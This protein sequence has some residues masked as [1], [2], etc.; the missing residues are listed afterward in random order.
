M[1]K[2]AFDSFKYF[3]VCLHQLGTSGFGE[4]L[5]LFLADLLKYIEEMYKYIEEM[6]ALLIC[7]FGRTCVTRRTPRTS[8]HSFQRDRP[9]KTRHKLTRFS[10]QWQELPVGPVMTFSGASRLIS[11]SC[12][13][14]YTL[15][16]KPSGVNGNFSIDE[17]LILNAQGSV[18][19]SLSAQPLPGSSSGATSVRVRFTSLEPIMVGICGTAA[20]TE[21]Y[22]R[23]K[24]K[25][26]FIEKIRLSRLHDE[27]TMMKPGESINISIVLSND[28]AS[29]HFIINVKDQLNLLT[30]YSPQNVSLDQGHNITIVSTFSAPA[31]FNNHTSSLVRVVVKTRG[32]APTYNYLTFAVTTIPKNALVVDTEPPNV[33]FTGSPA[34]CKAEHQHG[35]NCSTYPWELQFEAQDEQSKANLR[36]TVIR[37]N[38][39]GVNSWK[40]GDVMVGNYSSSCCFPY[41]EIKI[42]DMYGNTQNISLDNSKDPTPTPSATPTVTPTPTITPNATETTTPSA[43]PTPTV[44]SSATLPPRGPAHCAHLTTRRC[45]GTGLF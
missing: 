43:T 27:N 35:E 7:P 21:K 25:L 34:N 39:T 29:D 42:S 23:L 1:T 37:G 19:Q 5:P 18:V 40:E 28:G 22:Y 2:N 36:V 31:E 33:N 38:Q 20:E 3:W 17:V 4:F 44:T 14:E 11:A 10:I 6:V 12:N 16:V 24:T 9:Q 8:P 30:T 32:T 41:V 15:Q 13:K 45:R 26:V